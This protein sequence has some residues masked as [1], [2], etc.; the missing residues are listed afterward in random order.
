MSKPSKRKT[1]EQRKFEPG[2][3]L[4]KEERQTLKKR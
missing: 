2:H 4:N 3:R 1:R